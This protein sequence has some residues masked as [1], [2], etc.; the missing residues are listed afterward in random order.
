M[1]FQDRPSRRLRLSGF[2]VELQLKSTEYKSQDDTAPDAEGAASDGESS[3][4][5]LDENDPQSQIE[6]FN[7]ARLK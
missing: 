5:E 3:S 6:G 7:F 2:G 1:H 4:E